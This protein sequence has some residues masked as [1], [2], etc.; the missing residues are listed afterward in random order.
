MPR[1]KGRK[2]TVQT[3]IKRRSTNL[4]KRGRDE[5]QASDM[6]DL[7]L[8]GDSMS[9]IAAAY[10]VSKNAA[11]SQ[12]AKEALF[13]LMAAQAAERLEELKDVERKMT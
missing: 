13:R 1:L 9:D 5:T 11:Y 12:I 2:D 8:S 7:Y 6:L 10:D 3:R 4:R